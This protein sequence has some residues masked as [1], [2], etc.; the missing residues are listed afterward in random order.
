M[1][2]A[3]GAHD[4][5]GDQRGPSRLVGG[6]DTTAGVAMEVLVEG[7]QVV[8][9]RMGLEEADIAEDRAAATG[10]VEEDRNETVGE[11]VGQDGQGHL[12]PGAG[13]VL[14][15][16]VI[17]EEPGIPA[18]CL[19]DEVIDREPDRAAPVGVAAEQA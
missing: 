7:Q 16:D 3:A 12:A 2:A 19:D 13:G 5:V 14:D 17:T 10:V 15:Q 9:V 1:T 4:E 11:L 8:P 6:A 18:Q